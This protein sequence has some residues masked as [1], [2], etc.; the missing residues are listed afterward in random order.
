MIYGLSAPYP[1]A[2]ARSL[3]NAAE[4]RRLAVEGATCIRA[5]AWVTLSP[6]PQ[7]SSTASRWVGV[8]Q[9]RRP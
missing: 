1:S 5:A 8:R 7:Q 9:R 2:R 6:W 4:S 3:F